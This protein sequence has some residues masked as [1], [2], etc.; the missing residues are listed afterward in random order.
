MPVKNSVLTNSKEKASDLNIGFAN[1]KHVRS[2]DA[3][4]IRFE[5]GRQ[6]HIWVKAGD[7]LFAQSADHYVKVLAQVAD[8]KTWCTRHCTLKELTALLPAK[9]FKRISRFYLVNLRCLPPL[10]EIQK[11]L[12][13]NGDFTVTLKHRI[14]TS[15]KAM[16]TGDNDIS[17]ILFI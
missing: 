4:L 8:K 15:T 1:A 13:F 10:D 3:E 5:Y 12:C 14:I 9:G 17:R 16:L 2:A 6:M 7:M 11:S